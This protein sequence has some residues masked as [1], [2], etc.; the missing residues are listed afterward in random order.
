MEV[1]GIQLTRNS[2]IPPILPR[3]NRQAMSHEERLAH[4]REVIAKR[5][6]NKSR[7]KVQAEKK[8]KADYMKEYRLKMKLMREMMNTANTPLDLTIP[9][10]IPHVNS[11]PPTTSTHPHQA[12]LPDPGLSPIVDYNCASTSQQ[13]PPLSS[14]FNTLSTAQRQ[15]F[16]PL[17]RQMGLANLHG[18]ERRPMRGH[19]HNV[20]S[21][22]CTFNSHFITFIT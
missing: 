22:V 2:A 12:S 5:Q 13:S 16:P 17:H 19:C 18:P 20:T 11:T 15:L 3:I 8:K 21:K 1:S 14:S 6:A 10:Q 4:D 7:Q 9:K